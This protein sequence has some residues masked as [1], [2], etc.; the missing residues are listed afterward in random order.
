M[1]W[2]TFADFYTC[3]LTQVKVFSPLDHNFCLLT[4][5]K[6]FLENFNDA[7][8]FLTTAGSSA[9]ADEYWLTQKSQGFTLA[10]V[11]TVPNWVL[12]SL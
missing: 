6:D 1:I 10:A 9:L 2:D 4:L 11:L 7:A 8:I 3:L 12:A 5:R